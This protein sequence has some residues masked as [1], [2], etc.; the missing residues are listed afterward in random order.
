ML[1]FGF[2]EERTIKPSEV[3]YTDYKSASSSNRDNMEKRQK[4]RRTTSACDGSVYM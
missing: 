1:G 3:A 2:V 4:E